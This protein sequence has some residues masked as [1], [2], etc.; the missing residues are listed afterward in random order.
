MY[1]SFISVDAV[2]LITITSNDT[3]VIIDFG[4]SM[5]KCFY[6]RFIVTDITLSV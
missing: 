6:R 2:V 4:L 5:Y 3:L 1:R